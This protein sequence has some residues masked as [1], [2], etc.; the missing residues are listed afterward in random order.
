MLKD[1]NQLS[2]FGDN[3]DQFGSN[4]P[5]KTYEAVGLDYYDNAG[6]VLRVEAVSMKQAAYFYNKRA[7][8]QYK[9]G[10]TVKER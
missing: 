6:P 1:S 10:M 2:F 5:I 4:K 9:Y 8:W 7:G 3:R